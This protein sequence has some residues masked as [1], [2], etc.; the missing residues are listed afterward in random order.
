MTYSVYT[1]TN[2]V[3]KR[4]YVGRTNNPERRWLEHTA[5]DAILTPITKAIKAEGKDQ[6][7]FKVIKT[8][9][10][11]EAADIWETYW[12]KKL[13]LTPAGVYNGINQKRESPPPPV[14]TR[15]RVIRIVATKEEKQKLRLAAA[16]A[17]L[18][19]AVYAKLAALEKARAQTNSDSKIIIRSK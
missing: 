17:G 5:F 15:E 6:F 13:R 10:T 4:T 12:I 3:S 11:R 16:H 8:V 19:V 2:K 7:E 18:S 9:E 14:N 1:I